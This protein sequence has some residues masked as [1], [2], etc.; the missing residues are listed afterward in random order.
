[1]TG[2]APAAAAAPLEE[3]IR[4]LANEVVDPCSAAQALPV[5]LVDMGLLLRVGL[6]P[7]PAGDG[8]WAVRLLLRAT[9]PGCFYVV[10]FERELRLR[11]EALPEVA[12]LELDWDGAWDWTPDAIAPAVRARLAERRLLVLAGA[13]KATG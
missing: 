13:P 1:M 2:G 6:E 3:R 9:A 7:A 5:G 12:S 4:A 8:S 10:F 11:I